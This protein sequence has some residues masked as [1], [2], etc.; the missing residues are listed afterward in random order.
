M[1]FDVVVVGGGPAGLATAIRVRQLDPSISV[2]IVEKGSELGAHILSGAVVDPIGL[3]RLLPDWREQSGF[4]AVRVSREEYVVLGKTRSFA[5][6]HFLLPP[7]MSNKRSYVVSLANMC[8]WLATKAEAIGVDVFPGFAAAVLLYRPDGSVEGVATGDVG[9]RRD[10]SIGSNFQRGVAIKAKYVVLAEGARGS[11]TKIVTEK[12]KLAVNS[13]HQKYGIGLK[14]VWQVSPERHRPGSILHSFCWP[15]DNWTGGGGFFYHLPDG[16]VAVGMVI[17]LDYSNPYLSPFEEFQR[18]K[19]HPRIAPVFEGGTRISYGARAVSE[20]GYQSVPKL[21]FP[22]GLLVGDGA[23]FMN[24]PRIKGSQ[25]AILSGML[26]AAHL[27]EAIGGGR[28]ADELNAYDIEWR[29]GDIGKDLRPVRNVKPLWSRFGT[30]IGVP[31]GGLDMWLNQILNWSP[32]GTMMHRHRDSETLS[33][34]R[35]S[36]PIVYPKPDGIVS[37]DRLSSVYLSGTNH[38]EDQPVHLKVLDLELQRR[39]EHDEYAGPSQRYCPAGVYEWL[40]S[41][42]PRLQINAQNCLHCKV[43]DIKDP[44]QNIAWTPPEG[45]GGPLYSNM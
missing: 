16:K 30:V 1:E 8:R 38:A 34:A 27:V 24:V 25:N 17:H 39:S 21:T 33:P 26:A 9:I 22:G 12:F 4:E 32:F 6:P 41:T 3:D 20:G 15:L 35:K 45:G 18:F 44:N 7:I 19:T 42:P 11:L 10:G 14:E 29:A 28:A 40:E 23:G 5:L 37:F 31:L 43:C 36:K 13:S 2:A